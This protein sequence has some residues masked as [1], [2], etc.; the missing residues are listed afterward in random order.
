[1]FSANNVAFVSISENFETASP[2]GKAMIGILSVFAQLEREQIKER[3]TLGKLGRVKAGKTSAWSKVPFGYS[4]T[5]GE[6][7]PDPIQAPIVKQIYDDYLGGI[8]I[9]KLVD[10][11]NDEGHIGKDKR[12]SYRTVRQ[13]LDNAVYAGLTN[14]KGETYNGSHEPLIEP[15]TR[16]IVD[17]ELEKRQRQAYAKNNNPRPFQAK[18]LL[19]GL[20]RCGCCTANMEL[21]Q[22]SKKKDGTRTKLYKCYSQSSKKHG[23]TQRKYDGCTNITYGM[24]TLEKLILGEIEKL[25]LDDDYLL[26]VAGS[27]KEKIDLS[28]Y[29]K[30]AAELAKQIERLVGLYVTGDVP[31]DVYESK[32]KEIE[33][34]RQAIQSKIDGVQKDDRMELDEVKRLLDVK[35]IQQLDYDVQKTIVRSLI[36]QISLNGD[37]MTIRWA[38]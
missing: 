18:Y 22:R 19:S 27:A 1:M 32:K 23:R 33:T 31:L 14:F 3:M 37:D 9:T 36:K 4:Y 5:D 34:E 13:V 24:E 7:I 15:Q 2:F 30:R 26:E 25:R 28:A 38:F 16:Q 10:K 35:D 21:I 8:S 20:L 6:L 11:L 17:M 12:W 29:E